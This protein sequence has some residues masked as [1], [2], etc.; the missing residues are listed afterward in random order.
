LKLN[1][2]HWS[3]EVSRLSVWLSGLTDYAEAAEILEKVGRIHTSASGAWNRTQKW[4]EI[5]RQ[6]EEK[7]RISAGQVELRNGVV[8][9]EEQKDQ[10]MGVSMDGFMIQIRK[11]GWKEVKAGCVFE[12]RETKVMD[13]KTQEEIDVG[14]AMNNSYTA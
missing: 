1:E 8:P 9:G 14:C 13:E 2:K 4:G 7:E 10:R 6:I 3:E 5:Y 12:V 11:E